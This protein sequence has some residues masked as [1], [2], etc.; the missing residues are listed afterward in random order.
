MVRRWFADALNPGRTAGS[1]LVRRRF[2]A[3]AMM[4]RTRSVAD[5]RWFS[6]GS[7]ML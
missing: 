6:A 5:Q 3:G 2:A 1:L 4:L 7:Q